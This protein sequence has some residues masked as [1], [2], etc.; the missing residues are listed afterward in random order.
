MAR[1]ITSLRPDRTL[2]TVFCS[3]FSNSRSSLRIPSSVFISAL[4][5]PTDFFG[6]C[7]RLFQFPQF[8]PNLL[9]PFFGHRDRKFRDLF[10]VFPA[11]YTVKIDGLTMLEIRVEFLCASSIFY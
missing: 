9:H 6:S 8:I 4:D 1:L 10:A 2:L 11:F 7:R 5:R 3:S